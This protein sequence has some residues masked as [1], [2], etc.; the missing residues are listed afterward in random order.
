MWANYLYV[1]KKV[2]LN[3]KCINSVDIKWE[4]DSARYK[5]NA[6]Y[7]E[8]KVVKYQIVTMLIISKTRS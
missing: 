6:R 2:L 5:S 4:K 8:L 1:T 3:L 7:G